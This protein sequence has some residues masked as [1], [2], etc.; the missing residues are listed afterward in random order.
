[1]APTPSPSLLDDW[2]EKSTPVA[3]FP[4]PVPVITIR[5]PRAPLALD[6]NRSRSLSF[7]VGDQ[8]MPMFSVLSVVS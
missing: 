5:T 6:V 8:P 2:T 7:V 4:S 3:V 1:M